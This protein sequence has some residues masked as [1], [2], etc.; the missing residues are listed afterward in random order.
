VRRRLVA[1]VAESPLEGAIDEESRVLASRY[2]SEENVAAVMAFLS[3]K[4]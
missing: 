1:L 3:R 4:R 2:G